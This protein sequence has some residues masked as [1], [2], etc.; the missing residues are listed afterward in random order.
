M[1]QVTLKLQATES[2]LPKLPAVRRAY[3]AR[4]LAALRA[5]AVKRKTVGAP[6]ASE[7]EWDLVF[8]NELD[9]IYRA[10]ADEASSVHDAVVDTASADA[11]KLGFSMWPLALAALALAYAWSSSKQRR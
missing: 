3:W 4:M 8:A 9:R 10:V 2:L 6:A 5:R 1:A 7:T 11:A